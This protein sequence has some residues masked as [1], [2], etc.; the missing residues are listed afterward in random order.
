MRAKKVYPRRLDL[1]LL[2]TLV[3]LLW[4]CG[5]EDKPATG[6]HAEG[7]SEAKAER[8]AVHASPKSL[9]TKKKGTEIS[10]VV[11]EDRVLKA[12]ESPYILVGNLEVMPDIKLTIEPGVVVK[13]SGYNALIV[14]GNLQAKGTPDNPIKFVGLREGEKW[15]GIRF[16]KKSFAYN[17]EDIIEGHGCI[18]EYCEI[19]DARVG[20]L[21]EKASPLIQHNVVEN[22]EEGIKC[23]DGSNPTIAY[24]LLKDNK[25]GITCEKYSSPEIKNN[26]ITG[27]EGKGIYCKTYSSPTIA[28]NTI[29]GDGDTWWVGVLCQDS[30][31]PKINHNNIYANGGANIKQ[32]QNNPGEKSLE[33]DARNNWWGADNEEIIAKGVY[34]NHIKANLGKVIYKPYE[35]NKISNASHKG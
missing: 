20:I 12:S 5:G 2:S 4:G 33:V 35:S 1:W 8:H 27:K 13:S 25:D 6:G 17:S 22:C 34:D 26:T 18:I 7:H 16:G 3:V 23:R 31:A 21:C 9:L 15:D 28:Y 30:A 24:N 29:F 19:K 32:L 14:N 11:K 10:G